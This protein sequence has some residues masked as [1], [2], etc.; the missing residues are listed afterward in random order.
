MNVAITG[1]TRGLG[2]ELAR[3]FTQA[4]HNVIGFSRSTGHDILNQAVREQIQ[5]QLKE[6][7]VFVNNAYAGFAQVDLL[8]R[9]FDV[10]E[11]RDRKWI[12]N[13][14]SMTSYFEKNHHHPYAIHKIALDHQ[15]KQLQR[16]RKWPM[17]MN[18]RPSVID[19]DMGKSMSGPKMST[20]TAAG[21]IMFAFEHRNEFSVKDIVYEPV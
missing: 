20:T 10:W 9:A 2:A 16:I 15:A 11:N 17:I 13:I 12:I 19:T 5:E 18:F 4:G 8:N 3:H 21:V 14:G 7:S 1:H 6:C